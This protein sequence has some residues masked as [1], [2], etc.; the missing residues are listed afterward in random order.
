MY[1]HFIPY[2]HFPH[3]HMDNLQIHHIKACNKENAKKTKEKSNSLQKR[4]KGICYIEI[5]FLVMFC[6]LIIKCVAEKFKLL[7][8][9]ISLLQV[10]LFQKHLFL[11]QLTHNMT[12]DCS[13]NYQFSRTWKEHVLPIFCACRFNVLNW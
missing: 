10:N 9:F 3:F 1:G 12:K 6:G 8:Y 2:W 5:E 11:H 4:T 13:L 7:E